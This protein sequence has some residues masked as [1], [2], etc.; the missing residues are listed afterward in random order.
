MADN[1]DFNFNEFSSEASRLNDILKGV[2]DTLKGTKDAFSETNNLANELNNIK[3]EDLQNAE[4][5]KSLQDQLNKAVRERQQRQVLINKLINQQAT[6]EKK[7][8][9]AISKKLQEQIRLENER[10]DATGSIIDNAKKALDAYEGQTTTLGKLQNRFDKIK[11]ITGAIAATGIVKNFLELENTI[12]ETSKQ[13]GISREE[14]FGLKS[15]LFQASFASDNLAVTSTAMLKSQKALNDAMGTGL[16]ISAET[17]TQMTLMTDAMGLSEEAAVGFAKMAESSGMSAEQLKIATLDVAGSLQQQTGI[18]LDNRRILEDVSKVSGQVR[19]NFGDNPALIAEAVTQ[20]KLLGAE[21]DDINATA[22]SLLDF[23]S[24]IEAE[25]RAELITGK[26]LNLERARAAALAGDQATL[27]EELQTQ[28]GSAAEF[29]ALNVLQQRELAS[30]FGLSADRVADILQNQEIQANNARSLKGLTGEQIAAD[31]EQLSVQQ[32]VAKIQE[33]LLATLG[34]LAP[35]ILPAVEGMAK[36]VGFLFQSK[37]TLPL[38]IGALTTIKSLTLA[39][40]IAKLFGE[41]AKFG[42]LGLA[43]AIGGV[44]T[45]GTLIAQNVSDGIAPA[46]NGPF[47]ITD[48]YG[49][50][51]ITARGDGLAVSPNINNGGGGQPVVIQ[52]TFSNF[53]ASGPYQLAETQRRQASPTFA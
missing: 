21:M 4:K 12:T 2:N 34:E 1:S 8:K 31:L 6:A 50:T 20:A 19:A 45:M 32:Q 40:A 7:G 29:G 15:E 5:R 24:S 18:Q 35:T 51:A 38:I 36:F 44:A 46:G 28:L 17:L 3:K 41:N 48:G 39:T 25:L 23:E 49:R 37:A 27:A 30:A 13:L 53:Q 42:P 52:N 33:S 26:Q 16:Q 9:E 14:A 11:G 47:T 43:A 22:N 10:L